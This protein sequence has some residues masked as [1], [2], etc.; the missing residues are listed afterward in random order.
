VKF[1]KYCAQ[2]RKP[3]NPVTDVS[4]KGTV[5]VAKQLAGEQA[6]RE[7]EAKVRMDELRAKARAGRG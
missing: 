5:Q 4:L 6:K 3:K 2:F 1:G 7:A